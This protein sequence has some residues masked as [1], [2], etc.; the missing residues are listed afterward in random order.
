[1]S[2]ERLESGNVLQVLGCGI[3]ITGESGCGKSELSLALVD[4]GHRL[5]ADDVAWLSRRNGRVAARADPAQFGLLHI[6]D[7]G[8]LEI[9]RLYGTDSLLELTALQLIVTLERRRRTPAATQILRGRRSRRSVLGI[10]LP[11]LTLEVG[12]ARP[13]PLLMECAVRQHLEHG[14]ERRPDE[15]G[16][17]PAEDRACA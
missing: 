11:C 6:R 2:D 16:P 8:V 14:G 3:W 13:L 7:L 5:V 10:D 12:A 4:R 1:M 9:G 17:D 15:S